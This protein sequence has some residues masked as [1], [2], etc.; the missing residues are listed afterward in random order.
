MAAEQKVHELILFTDGSCLNNG[1]PN[2]KA[3][4]GVFISQ[5]DPR[6]IAQALHLLKN[7][8]NTAELSAIIAALRIIQAEADLIVERCA[9]GSEPPGVFKATVCTDSEYSIISLTRNLPAYENNGYRTQTGAVKNKELIKEAADLIN[10]IKGRGIT[11]D[12]EKVA[13]HSPLKDGNF[14]ADL[15]ATSAAAGF[16]DLPESELKNRA[17]EVLDL[18]RQT[19][20]R[21][22]KTQ[23]ES[24]S[25]QASKKR[26]APSP[27]EPK[28]AKKQMRFT[29]EKNAVSFS[30]TDKDGKL[31]VLSWS[32]ASELPVKAFGEFLGGK[33]DKITLDAGGIEIELRKPRGPM[34]N[35]GAPRVR[36]TLFSQSRFSSTYSE[37]DLEECRAAFEQVAAQ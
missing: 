2:A 27:P 35:E 7:T 28:P 4:M 30:H 1:R 23:K 22:N 19:G 17:S 26:K 15:L 6:N 25:P 31:W 18:Y 9:A 5:Y 33:L 36:F 29:V 32:K 20:G 24:E 14:F 13:G 8:N 37:F 34:Q 10:L 21:K 3:G 12:F 11:F 16:P